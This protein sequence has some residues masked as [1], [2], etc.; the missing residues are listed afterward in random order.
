MKVGTQ[1]I[2]GG[3]DIGSTGAKL[4]VFNSNGE[5]LHSGYQTYP[6]HRRANSHEIDGEAI[7]GSAKTLIKGANS[8]SL[9]AIGITS[10]GDS[11]VLLDENENTLLPVMLYTDP[12]G[13]EEAI[14]IS[15]T[16]GDDKICSIAGCLPHSIFSLPKLM[17]IKK[18]R[19][20]IYHKAKY[21][22]LMADFLGYRLTGNRMIDYSLATRTMGFDIQNLC[23]S[24]EIFETTEIDPILF[25]TPVPS[26]TIAGVI[27][28]NLAKEL[29]VDSSLQ[30]VI[31][32]HDQVAAATGSKVLTAGQATDGAGTV[33]CITPIFSNIPPNAK[34]QQNHYTV[35][36][37]L[38]GE[39]YCTYAYSY[40]GGALIKWF[41]DIFA[42]KE[43][44]LAKEQGISVYEYLESFMKDEPT[45]ILVLPHFAGAATP[46]M[47]NGSRGAFIG[48]Q[49][50][51][52]ISD[53]Y[54]ACIEGITYEMALNLDRLRDCGIQVENLCATGGCASSRLWL[55]MKADILNI[56]I[57]RMKVDE[58][59]TVGGIMLT[60]IA[61]GVFKDLSTAAEIL[62]KPLETFYPRKEMHKKY[63]EIYQRYC[64][65]YE[66]IR[67]LV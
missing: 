45:G 56:P 32:S 35:V 54:R 10:F 39:N 11:F 42:T 62:Q 31:C 34:L 16:L 57:I 55:Q 40:T 26:G 2:I 15:Q 66:A 64:K 30:I 44:E 20:D 29:G 27:R 60:G 48:L 52:N 28:P 25:S 59:G 37:F 8:L 41:V 9:S 23:W 6:V 65:V 36:P 14:T 51:N 46:Y 12:R 49:L 13:I 58:A 7:W 63:M 1:M 22:C 67:P 33:A 43:K 38:N 21:C 18:H 50:S 53:M 47:D 17:W 5:I 4:T 24:N 3:L 19:P 61:I